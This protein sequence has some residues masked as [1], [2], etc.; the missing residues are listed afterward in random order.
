MT[1]LT[2]TPLLVLVSMV[3]LA[4]SPASA[5]EATV[6]LAGSFQD[7]LGCAADWDP[8]LRGHLDGRF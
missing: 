5:E 1:A 3:P 2:A 7:E 8:S 4:V 6:T